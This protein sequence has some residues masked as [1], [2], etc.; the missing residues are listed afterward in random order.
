MSNIYPTTAAS[1]IVTDQLTMS[2]LSPP[3]ST[4][5]ESPI[6]ADVS[7]APSPI[8]SR[9]VLFYVFLDVANGREMGKETVL[10]A[11]LSRRRV[12]GVKG[13][14]PG[15]EGARKFFVPKNIVTAIHLCRAFL[16]HFICFK[17]VFARTVYFDDSVN[18][19]SQTV[20][21]IFL[22]YRNWFYPSESVVGVIKG[23]FPSFS[24]RLKGVVAKN[25][26]GLRP[27]TPPP[28]V[29]SS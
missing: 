9:L 21:L 3:L 18:V 5:I 10:H 11:G 17:R 12:E 20:V 27:Q 2:A 8:D 28:S 25:F 13:P 6:G 29:P 22:I 23:A 7:L 4:T 26:L 14:G 1:K 15:P 16:W 19:R 24:G